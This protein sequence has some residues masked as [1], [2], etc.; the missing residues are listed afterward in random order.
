MPA[1]DINSNDLFLKLKSQFPKIRLGNAEGMSTVNPKEAVFFDFDFV[2]DGNK[3]ASISISTAEEGI[4]KLFYSKDI[5]Q[6]QNNI[7]KNKWFDFL[8]GMRIFAKSNLMSFEPSD[9]TKKNL[10]KRDYEQ[11]SAETRPKETEEAKMN[12]STLYGSTKSSYQ[13]LENAKLIIRHSQ[14]VNEESTGS[15]TRHIS[16][17][18]VE[19]EGGER[20]QYPFNHLSGARAMM[21][22]VANGGN[23]YDN[24]GQYIV[25]LSEQVYNLRK[26]NSLVSRNA[27][28]ENTEIAGIAGAARDKTVSIKKTLERAQK[29][30]GYES[31]K[32]SFVEYKK[33]TLDG[34][35]LEALKNKFTLQQF[36]E[37]L[38]ELFPYISDLIGEATPFVKGEP[39]KGQGKPTG[40]YDDS[41]A[42]SEPVGDYK[43]KPRDES[44]ELMQA[45][46]AASV[47]KMEPFDKA[48]IQKALENT[49]KQIADFKRAAAENPKDKK[50][51]YAVEKAE[52]RLGLLKGRLASAD[53][54]ASNNVTK[55]ALTIEH[56]ATHVKDDKISLL[57]SR[58]SDDY[59]KMEKD[60]Q[61][62]VN[63]TIKKMMSKVKLVPMF[64]NESTSFNELE[65]I[66]S[67]GGQ[68]PQAAT[69]EKTDYVSEF[70]KLLDRTI[71]EKS[72]ILS[73]D[74]D[75]RSRA[76]QE[77]NQLMSQN[78]PAGTNGVNAI[79]SLQ[80]IIDDSSLFN[81]FKKVSQEDAGTCVRPMI[82]DW[83]KNN[84]PDLVS[85]IDTGDM[86]A[87]PAA[88]P[89]APPEA[90]AQAAPEAPPEE[91]DSDFPPEDDG[92]DG[93]VSLNEIEEFVKSL[94]NS[95]DGTFPRGEEGVKIAVEKK[96]GD[97]AGIVAEKII[98]ALKQQTAVQEDPLMRIRELAG[99]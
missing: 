85:E 44:Y 41:D 32:E 83:I 29:Q 77:L 61:R 39:S 31:I 96:F 69:S 1:N 81:E 47:I 99:L 55:N 40:D 34:A 7:V 19:N 24:F 64:S 89:E 13:K 91:E 30:A 14:K 56:L 37:E 6:Q 11:M 33:S 27:F 21:R 20:F 97:Q 23:P 92:R 60:E 26:F 12:E 15:R 73:T 54:Q 75:V 18:F 22:H 88:A 68:A 10:D 57:L 53:P 4:L 52:A 3:I 66:L 90:P 43:D 84:A 72:D 79:E 42:A 62:E 8:K 35:T 51:Q 70:E 38:V 80:G 28:L 71:G 17:I 74:E 67:A 94:F 86:N 9:I 78:F 59:P 82:M 50:A 5:L 36:N 49:I 58:I 98:E 76:V 95:E 46:D 25:G 65:S 93:G 2:V 63:L 16:A 45:V 87:E 48:S